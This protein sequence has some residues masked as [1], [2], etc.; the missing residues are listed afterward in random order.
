MSYWPDRQLYEGK[1]T[2]PVR[3][4]RTADCDLIEGHRGSCAPRAVV[5]IIS[6]GLLDVLSAAAADIKA[7]RRTGVERHHSD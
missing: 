6:S 2:D 5:E 4:D 7:G 1:W 3:C